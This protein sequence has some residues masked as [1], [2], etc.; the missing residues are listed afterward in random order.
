MNYAKQSPNLFFPIGGGNEIGASSYFIQL[1]GG[2]FLLDSGIRLGAHENSPRFTALFEEEIL[3]GLWDLDAVLISHGHLDHVGSL[4]T[5]V[6]EAREIS[7]YATRPTKDIVEAQL[8]PR[9]VDEAFI[10]VQ[11]V[12]EFN[13]KRVQR[14]IENIVPIE[15]GQPIHLKDCQIT[16]FCA[17]HILGAAMIYIETDSGNV[18]FT[19]DF[20]PFDQMTVPGYRVPDN[21]E[22]D[23]LITESTY[24]YQETKHINNITD[25]REIFALKIEKCLGENGNVLIPA[26]AIGRSQEVA[27]IL[28]NLIDEGKLAPFTIY[29]GGLAQYFCEI[30]ERYKVKVFDSNIQKAP[31]DL[32]GNLDVFSGIIVASS[33]MLLDKSASAKYAEK[34]LPDPRST[35]FFSGYLDEESPGHK[36]DW[37]SRSKGESFWLNGKSIPVNATVDTYR[38]SAHTDNEGILTL[39]E[40]LHPQKVIFVHGVPQYRRKISVF[41]ETLRRFQGQIDVYHANNGIPI[42]F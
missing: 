20:T 24:G 28:Q 32:E 34:I 42:Y 6:H 39:I 35:I 37:L 15:W 7:I 4:P 2:K 40:K 26:F 17:G 1:N 11:V 3:D 21:L 30:Y 18:L 5:V 10:D 25:E 31:R 33:G 29:I 8:K 16:F 9:R 38:L 14:V 36:L 41:R 23:L 12:N 22:V 27:L 19:G 13:E